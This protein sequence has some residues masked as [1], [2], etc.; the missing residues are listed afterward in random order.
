MGY[1]VTAEDRRLIYASDL[2]HGDMAFE[3]RLIEFARGAELLIYDAM[4][5]ERDFAR[6]KGFGHS[7]WQKGVEIARAAEVKSFV[8]FH[9]DP[10]H[11][12]DR[13]DQ[14]ARE[15]LTLDPTAR[16]A[17]EGLALAW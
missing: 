12:D 16:I 10:D 14:I 2:E 5:D 3:A 13:L 11:D 15:L 7:T 6:V 17:R 1:R 8:A 4:Y 9:H